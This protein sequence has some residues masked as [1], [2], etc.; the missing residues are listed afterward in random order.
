[1]TMTWKTSR[2]HDRSSRSWRCQFSSPSSRTHLCRSH[3]SG[4]SPRDSLN[5]TPWLTHPNPIN[6][7]VCTLTTPSMKSHLDFAMWSRPA[8]LSWANDL[9]V[10]EKVASLMTCVFTGTEGKGT[11]INSHSISYISASERRGIIW[12][13]WCSL[14]KGKRGRS[15]LCPVFRCDVYWKKCPTGKTC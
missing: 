2:C 13:C 8:C 9:G 6:M 3:L 14:V 12:I 4:R 15:A 1:M 10:S 11:N 5:V 7:P